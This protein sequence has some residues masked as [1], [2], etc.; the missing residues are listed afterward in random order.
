MNVLRTLE[1]ITLNDGTII[2]KGLICLKSNNILRV[3]FSSS[4]VASKNGPN[5]LPVYD[6][7]PASFFEKFED[8]SNDPECY[9]RAV[10]ILEEYRELLGP[11]N[12]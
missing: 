8:V 2:S 3:T 10:E 9:M 1:S 7:D 5:N 11:Q 12:V 4:D 6:V